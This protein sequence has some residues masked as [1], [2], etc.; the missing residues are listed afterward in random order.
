SDKAS[1][2][3]PELIRWLADRGLKVL[4]DE[5]AAAYA[6]RPDGIPRQGVAAASDLIVVL[7]GDGTLLSTARAALGRDVPIVAVNLGGLG[8]LTAIK[9]DDLYPQLERVLTGQYCI[10]KRRLMHTEL[11]RD[12]CQVNSWE[13]LNDMVLTKTEI[14]RMIELEVFVDDHFV[15]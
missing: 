6:A 15:C 4:F 14:A 1:E 7:G 10:Q 13:A 5:E 12:G 2:L 3:I 8:F 9:I 11:W